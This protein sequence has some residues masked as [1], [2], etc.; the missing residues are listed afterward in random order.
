MVS[1]WIQGCARKFHGTD[2]AGDGA[3]LASGEEIALVVC[4][5]V[6]PETTGRDG[7]LKP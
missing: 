6:A 1:M 4:A 5:A 3:D 7:H 2:W